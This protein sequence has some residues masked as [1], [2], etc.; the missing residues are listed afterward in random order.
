MQEEAFKENEEYEKLEPNS[1]LIYQMRALI[2]EKAGDSF[3]E[4]INW[5]KFNILKGEKE[6]ALN[7]F[8]IAYQFNSKNAELIETI[9]TQ[10]EAQKD[11]TKACEFY[12]KLINLEPNNSSALEKLATFRESIGD[13]CSAFE[14]IEKLKQVDPRSQFVND[15]YEKF[16]EQAENGGSFMNFLKKIF[17]NKMS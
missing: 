15:N 1:P 11:V 13:Y 12:E 8:M 9:A 7:E 10:L 2:Y 16:K 4:H 17:G 3:N 5:G 14:Y 6:V